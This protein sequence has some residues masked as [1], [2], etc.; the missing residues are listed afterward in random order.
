[1]ASPTVNR[2]RRTR[3]ANGRT[4]PAGAPDQ[5]ETATPTAPGGASRQL[6]L[7]MGI[8]LLAVYWVLSLALSPE[9]YLSTDVGGKTASLAAMEARGDWSTD[10]G[11]WAA[12][13]DPN[14]DVFPY[15]HTSNT[16]E[17]WWVN[18]SSLPMVMLA[19]PLWMLGG[20]QLVLLLPMLSAVGAALIAGR[21]QSRLD[22]S[23]GVVAT[24][25]VGLA[26]PLT[27]YAL[28]FW[29]HTP[30]VF[31][32]A[33][34]GW[35]ALIA[36]ER[37]TVRHALLAGAGFALAATMR[38]EALVYGFGAGLVLCGA[39][40]QKLRR[41][42]VTVGRAITT[43][44]AMAFSAVGVL[45][46]SVVGEI[47]YYGETLRSGRSAEAA[48]ATTSGVG[49]RVSAGLVTALSPINA[50]HP[51]SYVLGSVLLAGLLW[52]AVSAER[53]DDLRRPAI[54]SVI[55]SLVM[56]L[57]VARF[58][59]TFIPGLIPTTV[60]AAAGAWFGL[61]RPSYRLMAALAL[62]P[63]PIVFFTQYAAGAVPQWGGRY[64]LFTGYL[65]TILGCTA[66]VKIHKELFWTLVAAGVAVTATGVWFASI[67]T[68]LIEEDFDL[69]EAVS[70]G[71][72]VVW[73][74]PVIA[75]EGGVNVIGQRWLTTF[76]NG[77]T[78]LVLEV[79]DVNDV[80]RFVF[81]DTAGAEAPAFDGFEPASEI[82][83]WETSWIISQRLT[84]FERS[85][86]L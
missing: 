27:V 60:F 32:M 5:R 36:V 57:R 31:F 26:T 50:I 64:L 29:E 17:G 44:G 41:G 18:T 21:L 79:L 24:L 78:D 80:D 22:G 28:D 20:G 62:V 66:L 71:E 13:T 77:Q 25:L 52:L 47:L 46:A 68:N 38:Q 53:G 56:L 12:E 3:S 72:V 82:G 48:T 85:S 84:V 81:I 73:Y 23:S 43:C 8:G 6:M 63:V 69:I 67:R 9:G 19:R 14:G 11:Y 51:L 83:E 65:L 10:L 75:R 76:G 30:G 16:E 34:G 40:V 2:T 58:G 35:A 7:A 86:D 15:A 42:D 37:S 54:V 59:P 61:R 1:M 70:D 49:E 74:D 4:V 33:L 55:V 39:F 45:A